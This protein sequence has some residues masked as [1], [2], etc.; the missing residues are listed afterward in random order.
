M[1]LGAAGS[2]TMSGGIADAAGMEVAFLV[3]AAIGLLGFIVVWLVMPET[4]PAAAELSLATQ[5]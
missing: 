1:Y 4:R 2:T 5:E 3:L